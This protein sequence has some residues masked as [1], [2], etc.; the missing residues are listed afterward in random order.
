MKRIF[1]FIGLKII[2][3]GGVVFIPY[4]IGKVLYHFFED[5]LIRATVVVLP[6]HVCEI[7]VVGFLFI[8]LCI[9]ALAIVAAVCEIIR[10]NWE[11]AG[12]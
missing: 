4:Y 1:K 6:V 7:W 9:V 3:I 10:L 12:K 5:W 8:T 2:E 11:W